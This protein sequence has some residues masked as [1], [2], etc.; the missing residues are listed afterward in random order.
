MS[1]S[2]IEGHCLCNAIR[3]RV[4]RSRVIS[5]HHCHCRDCQRSTGSGFT[6]FCMVPDAGVTLVQGELGSCTVTGDSGNTVTRSFCRD[7]GS[8][9]YSTA[10][11]APGLTL[12]KAGCLEDSSWIEPASIFWTDSAQPWCPP[13]EGVPGHERNPA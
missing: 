12:V 10:S 4:D 7:C 6:T 9:I 11:L 13:V 8:P 3:I 5:A 2:T 1:D